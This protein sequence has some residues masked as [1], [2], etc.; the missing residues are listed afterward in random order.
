MAN[1]NTYIDK[2]VVPNGSDTITANLVDTVSGYTKNTGTVTSV[3]LSN[4]T[5]GGLTVSD[6]PITSSGTITIE[7]TNKLASA[8]TTQKYYPITFDKNGHITG[9][10]QGVTSVNP[11][12]INMASSLNW[13]EMLQAYNEGRDIIAY[14]EYGDN[15]YNFYK[16][17]TLNISS[18]T[19][20]SSKD[21]AFFTNL[22]V[23]GSAN[24]IS[25][26]SMIWTGGGV[27]WEYENADITGF[28]VVSTYSSTGTDAVNG[29]AVNAALQ[30]L[31]SSISST[32][33][34]AI[35][36]ITITDGKIASSTK[37]SVGETNQNAFSNVKVGSTTIAADTTTDTL[38]L[39]AGTGITLTPD[40]TNDKV[41]I[42][43]TASGDNSYRVTLSYDSANDSFSTDK[44]YAEIVAAINS[45]K[46]AYIYDNT[47]YHKYTLGS[48]QL[49][50]TDIFAWC[51][52]TGAVGAGALYNLNF[53]CYSL[54]LK[55]EIIYMI[56]SSNNVSTTT[57]SMDA[58]SAVTDVRINNSSIVTTF[59]SSRIANFSTNTA[60][61][62]STNKIATMAD[63][64]AVTITYS[65]ISGTST[66]YEM[67]I[68]S[69]LASNYAN[70]IL[71]EAY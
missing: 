38:E 64:D 54:L 32:T 68:S 60:Y 26:D 28:D 15:C 7:H 12:Y 63:V 18:G 10:S 27:G 9:W 20:T 39:V 49:G 24:R 71:G 56:D 62:S 48:Y 40:A 29:T 16:L 42:A 1:T 43:S 34:Q 45:G 21:G 58:S 25:A 55:A 8:Q 50:L 36:S 67:N 47:G 4:A 51:V 46:Q 22:I 57:D 59:G 33:G 19:G 37:I 31:D 3:G 17:T 61:N 44:T 52:S 65:L 23:D 41:T 14:E 2:I 13:S 70:T 11:Y 30:T 6:S 66:S 53:T 35:S 69:T 5:D